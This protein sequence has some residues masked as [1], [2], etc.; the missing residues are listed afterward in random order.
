MVIA[1]ATQIQWHSP[2]L[3]QPLIALGRRS[4]E[5]YLT[6]MFVVFALFGLFKSTG[7]SFGAIPLLFISV[8]LISGV[9]GGLVAHFYSEPLNRLIRQR[10]T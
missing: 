7:Q 3:L 1:V 9:V 4:Y 2:P 6:H 8:I 10:F 5:V